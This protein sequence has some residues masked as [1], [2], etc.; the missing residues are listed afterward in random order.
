VNIKIRGDDECCK[1]P[2]FQK[3]L[4]KYIKTCGKIKIH[5]VFTMEL[6]IDVGTTYSR[7]SLE[8]RSRRSDFIPRQEQTE[9]VQTHRGAIFSCLTAQEC[10]SDRLP[11]VTTQSGRRI[12]PCLLQKPARIYPKQTVGVRCSELIRPFSAADKG[13]WFPSPSTSKGPLRYWDFV[14]T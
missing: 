14:L 3:K 5:S 10:Q 8:Q 11:V 6:F 1:P 12:R 9:P 7:W 2:G 13:T 4:F